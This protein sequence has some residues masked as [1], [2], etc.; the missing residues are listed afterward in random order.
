MVGQQNQPRS[1][2]QEAWEPFLI[3]AELAFACGRRMPSE[4]RS[5][6]PSTIGKAPSIRCTPRR[7]P[8]SWYA[9]IAEAH[10]G[11]Q[12]RYLLEN[13]GKGEF[14]RIDPYAREVTPRSA[15]PSC[16]T[17]LDW[18]GDNFHLAAR[19]ELAIYEL[20]VGTF[21]DEQDDNLPGKFASISSRLG[22]EKARRQCDPDH[23]DCPVRRKVVVGL[24]PRPYLFS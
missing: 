1:E 8:R 23:A 21:N 10:I 9:D 3:R 19:N 6:A 2:T 12:Y 20:H 15:T 5:S 4:C 13:Y 18:E 24:Q 17:R 14:K 11:D 7:R 22:F 16:T